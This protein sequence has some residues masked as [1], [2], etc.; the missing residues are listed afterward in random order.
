[1]F[2]YIKSCLRCHANCTCLLVHPVQ[3]NES[4]PTNN[5]RLLARVFSNWMQISSDC[6]ARPLWPVNRRGRAQQ[7]RV[8]LT[9][10]P[11]LTENILSGIKPS[12]YHPKQEQLLHTA[13]P[14]ITRGRLDVNIDICTYCCEFVST[15]ATAI[16]GM[17]HL[18]VERRH[19]SSR[20][21]DCTY[22]HDIL[23]SNRED[24][25]CVFYIFIFVWAMQSSQFPSFI[26]SVL[27]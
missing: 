13:A 15:N 4:L 20:S 18:S 22:M 9:S 14:A 8:H 3:Q 17:T 16:V 1:M 23:A 12:K 11:S 7:S 26:P 19:Y 24:T 6:C 5:H 21:I 25:K 10:S 27:L 2:N